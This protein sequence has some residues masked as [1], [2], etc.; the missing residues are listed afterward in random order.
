MYHLSKHGSKK[1]SH[2]PCLKYEDH[3]ISLPFSM[4]HSLSVLVKELEISLF[5]Q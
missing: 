2:I 3:I 5:C 4:M 1:N